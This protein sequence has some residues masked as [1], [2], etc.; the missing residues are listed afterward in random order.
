MSEYAALSPFELERRLRELTAI[1]GGLR[2]ASSVLAGLAP[3]LAV[4]PQR[5]PVDR[6]LV[7]GAGDDRPPRAVGLHRGQAERSKNEPIVGER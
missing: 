4:S 5:F 1:R 2:A 3:G 7:A 6:M